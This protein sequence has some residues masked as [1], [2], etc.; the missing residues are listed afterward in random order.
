M[1]NPANKPSTENRD[2]GH[3]LEVDATNISCPLPLLKMKQALN[4]AKFGETIYV[5][6][7]DPVSERDFKSYIQMT[8]HQLE[9]ETDG[10]LFKY[11]IT[12]QP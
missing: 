2:K 6:V 8:N 11:W 9:M 12:K 5:K 7:T 3:T 10:K 4:Q 1:Q